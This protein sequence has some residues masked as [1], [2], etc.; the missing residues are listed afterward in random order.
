MG[1][2]GDVDGRVS[3]DWR[4]VVEKVRLATS[5]LRASGAEALDCN[6]ALMATRGSRS[7]KD[8]V[9]AILVV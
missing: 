5:R 6:A 2:V 1:D 4:D 7:L 3:S 8:E 9:A